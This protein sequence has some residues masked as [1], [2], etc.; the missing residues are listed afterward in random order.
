MI[1]QTC[2]DNLLKIATVYARARGLKLDTVGR[3]FYGKTGFFGELKRGRRSITLDTF[4]EIVQAIQSDWPPGV[5]WPETAPAVIQP[6]QKN[7]G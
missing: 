7:P 4:D 6:P 3:R 5:P 2:R 1:A